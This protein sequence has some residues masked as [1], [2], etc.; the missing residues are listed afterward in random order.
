LTCPKPSR[1]PRPGLASPHLAASSSSLS[2]QPRLPL[3]PAPVSRSRQI[4]R[5]GDLQINNLERTHQLSNITR[6]IC[7]LVS[8]MTI[9]PTT[10]HKHTTGM[11]DKAMSEVNFVVRADKPAKAQALE[12]IRRLGGDDS[13][14]KVQR[15]R[16]RVR[17]TMPAKDAKRIKDKVLAEVEETEEEEMGAEWEAVVHINPSAFRV[18]T[19][20]VNDET[21][22][23][24]RVESMGSVGA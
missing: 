20:L 2:P 7:T 19:D 1:H 10:S 3:A 17:I 22:G 5:K 4:L 21:K 23:K 14:L 16:M 15:V 24:G 12:L 8:E 18:L 11:I 9:D 13:P 6:E